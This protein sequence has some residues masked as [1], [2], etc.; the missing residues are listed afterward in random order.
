MIG[1]MYPLE[2]DRLGAHDAQPLG[3][4]PRPPAVPGAEVRLHAA[5][6]VSRRS[7]PTIR[8]KRSSRSA[9]R[10]RC[11]RSKALIVHMG[12]LKEG[13]KSLILV[14]EGYTNILPPQLREPDRAD[15]RPRQSERAESERGR[16]RHQRGSARAVRRRPRHASRT[17]GTSTTSRT[18]TTCRSTPSIRAG[19]RC[20][21]STS[22]KA[23]DSQTDH[24]V[25]EQHD[26]HAARR[27]R[28]TPT[29]ARSSTATISPSGMKQIVRDS[30]A[31]Y[32]IGY[33]STQAPIR[34]QVPRDQGAGEAARRAGARAQGLLGAERR[35]SRA[36]RR[37]RRSLTA[38]KPVENALAT[39]QPA[40]RAP[41][42]IRTW[43]GTSRGE[44]GKTQG[45]VRL[46]ADAEVAR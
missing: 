46:G 26:G 5:E 11:R 42:S 15:A 13:R 29:A 37:H 34:R 32:L 12:S 22:T 17:C 38:A 23:S 30:S 27:W 18:R 45:D 33:N 14:S 3:R 44:N 20:S 8:P 43:I 28:K 39:D 36:A 6:R 1:V 2:S 41:T 4:R 19:C 16:E 31:Y 7:T 40:G 9:T 35:G 10:C 24:A 21:S 25:L